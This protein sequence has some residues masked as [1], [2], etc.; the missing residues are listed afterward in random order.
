MIAASNGTGI[1]SDVCIVG[2]GPVGLALAFK[3]ADAGL[4]VTILEAGG[5]DRVSG[6]HPV[7]GPVD[8]MTA[9]H[10]SVDL[11]IHRGIG[12]ASCKWGGRCVP[13]DDLDFEVRDHVPFSGWPISHA[14][15]A[16][17]YPEAF[18]FLG[19]GQAGRATLAEQREGD[20]LARHFEGWSA[21]PDLIR[22]H[23]QRLRQSQ[24]ITLHSDS[25]VTG[26]ELDPDAERVAGLTVRTGDRSWTARAKAYVLAG[27]G[28][29]NA[30]LLLATQRRW[31]RKLGGPAGALGRF[32]CGHLTGYL[33]S[34]SLND[35][36]FANDLRQ[37]RCDDGSWLRRRMA[38]A[39]D[40]QRQQRLL[41][42]AFWLDSFS[43]ADPAHGSGA[44]SMLYVAMAL[45]GL[46][47]RLSK[48]RAPMSGS[49]QP[50]GLRE[51][52]HNVLHDPGIFR[53][54]FELVPQLGSRRFEAPAFALANPRRR[55]LLRY[56]AEQ[57]PDPDNRVRLS[58]DGR[59]SAPRLI[60]DYRFGPADVDSVVRSHEM[61]AE[62]LHESGVGR[63]DYLAEPEARSESV[64]SQAIDG[65]HQI[66]L[67]R[68]AADPRQGVVDG[69]CRVHDLAGLFVAGSSVFPTA[70]QANPT[71]PAVALALRLGDHLKASLPEKVVRARA[72]P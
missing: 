49:Q 16:V 39:A 38:V 57:S 46:Y 22:L 45:T 9:H 15:V 70:G 14:Q 17:Y 10:A 8:I 51:H 71:L 31:P 36:S 41:N 6:D 52:F 66:G 12:G 37:R 40:T 62:R 59:R 43:L 54:L 61:L 3:C 4:A 69:N 32:Y 56:H 28:L 30:R 23:G 34:I 5:E 27:G 13:L 25:A 53:G 19:C 50:P 11:T 18:E 68:M 64:L 72:E 24:L 55:Y 35:R 63:L 7:L 44:L 29:E 33:A 2:A 58:E 26:I 21:E 42:G 48:G 67:T 1:R 65:Y 47:S 20:G 60:V